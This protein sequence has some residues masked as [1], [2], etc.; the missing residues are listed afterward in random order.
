MSGLDRSRLQE[1]E[2]RKREKENFAVM[3]FVR[4]IIIIG[5]EFFCLQDINLSSPRL[6]SFILAYINI[7]NTAGGW[8]SRVFGCAP[9]N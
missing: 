4:H 8:K 3:Y 9:L 7:I 1:A 6:F 2:E 5:G